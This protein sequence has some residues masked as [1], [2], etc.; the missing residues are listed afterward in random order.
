MAKI[1]AEIL[2]KDFS[3]IST[4]SSKK[5]SLRFLNKKSFGKVK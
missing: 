2:K 4:K 3:Y 5:L 1:L